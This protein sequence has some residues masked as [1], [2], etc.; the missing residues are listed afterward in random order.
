[1]LCRWYCTIMSAMTGKVI[2]TALAHTDIPIGARII[3]VV[4][5]FDSMT[6][7]RPYRPA[8]TIPEALVRLQEEADTQLDGRLT[9]EWCELVRQGPIS[10]EEVWV[11]TS[12]DTSGQAVM[13]AR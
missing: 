7:D 9:R 1:M 6:S 4:D 12:H 11:A 3:A 10:G 5:T 13:H 2:P 8:L